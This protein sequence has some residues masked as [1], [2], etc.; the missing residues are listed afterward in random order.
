MH[1]LRRHTWL[2]IKGDGRIIKIRQQRKMTMKRARRTNAASR[3]PKTRRPNRKDEI[4]LAAAEQ[5]FVK[6]GFAGTSV[7]A[8][9][10]MAGVSKRTV[11]SNFETKQALYAEVIRKRAAQ[12]VPDEIDSEL[13]DADPEDTLLKISV[14]FLEGIYAPEQIAF[15]QTVVADS[16]QF[17]EVG[18]M[19]VEGPIARSQAVFDAY[20]R[21]QAHKD[22]MRFPNLEYAGAQ[23]VALLKTNVHMKLMFS[24]PAD[25]SRH[26]LEEIARSSIHLFLHGA[27]QRV[28][29]PTALA[30]T[31]RRK[32]GRSG[33]GAY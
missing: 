17:P 16:R 6:F 1:A 33:G 3:I 28:P 20:F 14:A 12:V 31:A 26:T 18:R 25:I 32:R 22:L 4:V 30:S 11:Y 8:I 29:L 9:A 5:A 13:I 24:Q 15:Y 2:N 27:L 21:K 10:E 23:F 19:L 7:D